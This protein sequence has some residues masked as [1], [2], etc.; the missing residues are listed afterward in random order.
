[1]C[2]CSPWK[3]MKITDSSPL[4]NTIHNPQTTIHHPP[5]HNPLYKPPLH[6]LEE[7]FKNER[8]INPACHPFQN[9]C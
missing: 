2:F 5:P 6:L 7:L 1:M 4:S 3:E 8:T 9:R